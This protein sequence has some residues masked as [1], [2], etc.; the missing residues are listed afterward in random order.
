MKFLHVLYDKNELDS[1][2]G[3]GVFWS[4]ME[5]LVDL[6]HGLRSLRR[7][8][9]FAIT[10]MAVLALGIGANASV[11]TVVKSVLLAPL[12]MRD[13]AQL[14]QLWSE[15]PDGSQYPFNIPNFADLRDRVQ[16]LSDVAAYGGFNANLVGEANPERILGVR[17]TGNFFPMLGVRAAIGRTL[18]PADD[19]PGRPRVVVLCDTL[20]RRRYAGDPLVLGRKILLNGEPY[21]VAGV[22]PP[23]FAFHNPAMEFAV[24]LAPDSDPWRRVRKSISFLRVSARLKP[25]VSIAQAKQ[26]LDRVNRELRDAFPETNATM[27]AVQVIPLQ[28][29]L[30]GGSRRMLLVLQAAVGFVLLAACANIAGLLVSRAGAR[31]KELAIRAALGGTRWRLGRQMLAESLFLAL[32]GS[33]A[34]AALA[35][36]G[37]RLMLALSPAE[38]PRAREIHVDSSVLGVSLGIGMLCGILFGV[39]PALKTSG[40]KLNEALRGDGRGSTSG[41]ARM[42]LRRVLVVAEVSIS[43]VLLTGAGLLLKSFRQLTGADPGFRPEGLETLRLALPAT[44]YRNAESVTRFHD[45]LRRRMETLPAVETAGA[46]SILP[47]SGPTAAAEFTI[48]GRP[49]VSKTEEPEAEYR[50]IDSTYLRTMGIPI[51]RGRDFSDAD[52]A[53]ARTVAIISEPLAR[54]YWGDQ[55]PVGSQIQIQDNSRGRR[56]AEI[57]GVAGPVRELG[58][59]KPPTPCL[60]VKIDQIPQDVVRFLIN[61]MFF[62][63]RVRPHAGAVHQVREL[64]RGIDSDVAASDALMENYLARATAPRR[65]SLRI[66]LCFA[67]AA[68]LLAASGLYGLVAFSTAQRTREIGVRMV[69][70]ASQSDVAWLVVRETVILSGA[71]LLLGSAAAWALSGLMSGMLYPISPH[72]PSTAISVALVLLAAATFASYVPMRRATRVDPMAALRHD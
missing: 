57:V 42:T 71:G 29:E 12:A 56:P 37:V 53:A 19:L 41:E 39:I 26:D 30:T 72:D 16:T 32:A 31:Q 36:W 7:E 65:F 23:S 4:A 24:A 62:A 5:L 14:V 43:L 52:T 10:V 34:G 2:N 51:L 55:N 6:R 15:R 69:M 20:W 11:F 70:G 33:L 47:M 13:P 8:P 17:A 64:I 38:L 49:P 67:A 3:A 28:E 45:E 60:F 46:I 40:A 61:N 27:I 9:G 68:L 63:V 58:L 50:M 59:D 18:E 1:S 35:G 54:R 44:R 21:I 22:M 66:L 48:D 25:G